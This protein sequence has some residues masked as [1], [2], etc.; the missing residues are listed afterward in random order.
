MGTGLIAEHNAPSTVDAFED[1]SL[2][3]GGGKAGGEADQNDKGG[4]HG[5]W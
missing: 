1:I 4:F 5:Q 2:R 3:K